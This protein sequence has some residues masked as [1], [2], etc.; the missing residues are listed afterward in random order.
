[1]SLKCSVYIG[2]SVDGFIARVDGSI[3]WLHKP[4][5]ASASTIGLSYDAF[6]STI[7]AVVMGRNSFEQVLTFEDWPYEQ[8]SVVVLTTRHL[9]LPHRLQGKV[10]VEKGRPAEVV[11]RLASDGMKH[12]YIDGGVTIQRFL[13]A[14]LIHEITIT[15][16]PVLLGNGRPLFGSLGLE[17]PLTH[18]VTTTSE[19]GCVQIRYQV[20]HEP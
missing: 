10:T 8:T 6:I 19:K 4:E 3:D 12:V 15:Q 14:G 9:S 2:A 7:D 11:A 5:Y 17:V 13:Q 1:M 18:L 16:L 20:I